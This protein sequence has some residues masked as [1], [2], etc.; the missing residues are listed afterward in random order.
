AAFDFTEI[1]DAPVRRDRPQHERRVDSAEL[2]RSRQIVDG[3][4]NPRSPAAGTLDL[5][6]AFQSRQQGGPAKLNLDGLIQ[7]ISDG[8][9][10]AWRIA[11]GDGCGR[12]RRAN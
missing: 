4:F 7:R 12:E 11:L 2:V 6:F 1:V 3:E 8:Y 9:G 5:R 10:A